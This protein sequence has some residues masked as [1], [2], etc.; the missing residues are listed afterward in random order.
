MYNISL[1]CGMKMN[2]Y[3]LMLLVVFFLYGVSADVMA[4][5]DGQQGVVHISENVARG[6]VGFLADDLLEGR[7]AGSR[8]AALAAAYIESLLMEWGIVPL[9]DNGYRQPFRAVNENGRWVTDTATLSTSSTLMNNLLAVIPGSGAGYVVVGAHYDHLGVDTTLVGDS[10]YNGADDN[11]SGISAV[12]QI[13]RAMALSG[14]RPLRTV[15]FAFWDGVSR[16]T[17]YVID[18]CAK[19]EIPCTVIQ[20]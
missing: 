18:Q 16:G 9:S 20:P 3:K 10:C 12:L 7:A 2:L 17:K 8:G 13:A 15:V 1:H 5:D 6:Y 14:A 11:A 4:Q 19:R